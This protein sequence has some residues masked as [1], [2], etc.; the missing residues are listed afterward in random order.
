MHCETLALPDTG[1]NYTIL[2][3][4]FARTQGFVVDSSAACS[5]HSVNNS[6]VSVIGTC[7]IKV[8]LG[9]L[10]MD[11]LALVCKDIFCPCILGWQDLRALR[12]LTLDFPAQQPAP[13]S[14]AAVQ[15]PR[16]PFTPSPEEEAA[17]SICASDI[18]RAFPTVLSDV[19]SDSPMNTD[20]PMV[21]TIRPDLDVPPLNVATARAVPRAYEEESKVVTDML[22]EKNVITEVSTPTAW[23][24][25]GFFVPKP[26]GKGRI[27]LVVDY[28]Q[29]NKCVL[30]PVHPFPCTNDILQSI[31]SSAKFF[32]VMDAVNGYYPVSYTHLTLPTIYSV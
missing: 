10:S 17:L 11:S 21:I 23:C 27:R 19:I 4:A 6:P 12:V 8:V 15:C 14:A 24:S 25:P 1:S 2:D 30:R 22:L 20:S 32:C 28:K 13:Q 7:Q 9:S 29:L 3:S 5:V 31:P 26:G 16:Q 18:K